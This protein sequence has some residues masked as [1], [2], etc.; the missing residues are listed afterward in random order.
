MKI[1]KFTKTKNSMYLLTLDN[2]EKVK[3][4]EDLI[5]KYG[6]LLSKEL[7]YDLM[8]EIETENKVYEIYDVALKYIKTRLR[9]KKELREYLLKKE[10]SEVSVNNVI[11]MLSNQGYLNDKVYAN[12]YVHDKMLMSNYGP[13]KIKGELEKIGISDEVIEDAISSFT[14]AKERERIEK[15]I[16]KQI[17]SNHN[18]GAFLLK[19]KIQSN[20]LSLGYSTILV[21]TCLNKTE[22]DST[23]IY[24]KEYDKLYNK[25]SKKY[26][27][28]ELE[29]KLKQKMYQKGF[30]NSSMD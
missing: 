1:I 4:H 23:D 17:K 13:N 30:T 8:K 2:G 28:K 19:R 10:Y 20:L 29:Y 11:D 5:L 24:K 18:K 26:S 6:L 16:A 25:L 14:E 15:I 27:G 7:S 12:S 3:I 9:S 22:F 21:N